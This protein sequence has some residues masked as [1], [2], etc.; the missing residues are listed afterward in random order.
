MSRLTRI[1]PLTLCAAAAAAVVVSWVISYFGAPEDFDK[2]PRPA[3]TFRS[4]RGPLR[5]ILPLGRRAFQGPAVI[6]FPPKQL[7]PTGIFED[8]WR[9]G[10]VVEKTGGPKLFIVSD[11]VLNQDLNSRY[12]HAASMEE[13][14]VGRRFAGCAWHAG[15]TSV[16]PVD[17]DRPTTF[18]CWGVL[19]VPH[20]YLLLALALW[21]IW[22]LARSVRGERRRYFGRCPAC[23]YDMR[24][25][26]GRCPECGASAHDPRTGSRK[27]RL[28]NH[29]L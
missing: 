24:A 9:M 16:E 10:G 17:S 8:R 18:R 14:D 29:S 28:Q 23:G 1:L 25:T 2:L 4:S 13:M 7:S 5:V 22:S 12:F 20:I 26:P 6:P 11:L 3:S 15:R 19:V 21:P 27:L